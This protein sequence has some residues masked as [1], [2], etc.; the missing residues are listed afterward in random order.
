MIRLQ[1][2]RR[3]PA[4]PAPS[5]MPAGPCC[6]CARRCPAFAAGAEQM[7]AI[8]QNCHRNVMLLR[9]LLHWRSCSLMPRIAPL[10]FAL[11]L[12]AGV[13][14]ASLLPSICP[15]HRLLRAAATAPAQGGAAGGDET[16]FDEF[17]GNDAGVLGAGT[18]G[19]CHAR[20]AGPPVRT[21]PAKHAGRWYTVP[22]DVG[23]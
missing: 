13:D 15:S 11:L 9:Q 16:K 8:W 23:C 10:S 18:W 4:S 6:P 14:E 2:Q 12:V 1:E 17:L 7:S 22:C 20:H 5:A 19:C 21:H 3:T